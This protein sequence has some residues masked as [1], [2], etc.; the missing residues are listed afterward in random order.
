MMAIPY[1]PLAIANNFLER[2]GS[3]GIEHMKLQKLVYCSYGWWLSVYKLEGE[4]LTSEGPEIWRHGPVFG[5]LYHALKVFGRAPITE[6]KSSSPFSVPDNVDEHD[7]GVRNLI[8]WIWGRYGHMSSFALSDITHKPGTPWHRVATEN[9]FSVAF[10]TDIPDVYIY[11]EFSE[12]LKAAEI[13][14]Q[15][16]AAVAHEQE[17]AN[18]A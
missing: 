3:D 2:F 15:D 17:K 4:R 9:N 16:Q 18:P 7:E 5:S 1:T 10:N 12:L 14:A 6:P 11:E 8:G 13:A